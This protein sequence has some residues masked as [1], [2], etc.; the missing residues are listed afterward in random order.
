MKKFGKKIYWRYITEWNGNVIECF[1]LKSKEKGYIDIHVIH[2]YFQA[3]E[4]NTLQF[5][6]E[7][8]YLKNYTNDLKCDLIILEF[9]LWHKHSTNDNVLSFSIDAY[10]DGGTKLF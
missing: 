6:E 8:Q 2:P 3:N 1:I 5:Q 10:N 4:M 9:V 7:K